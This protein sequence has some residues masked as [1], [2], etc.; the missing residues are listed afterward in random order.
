MLKTRRRRAAAVLAAL[1]TA[2]AVPAIDVGA[3]PPAHAQSKQVAE[4]ELGSYIVI[5][6][7]EPLVTTLGQDQLQS[8]G[9]AAR[10]AEMAAAHN[11]LLAQVGASRQ[12]KSHS[13]TNAVNGFSAFISHAQAEQ[14]AAMPGVALVVPDELQQPTT[15]ASGDYL[16][17]T[18][19]DAA[20][21]EGLTGEDVV[22][23]VIDSGIWPEH[24]SF[25][26]DGNYDSP[27]VR[28]K[29]VGNMQGQWDT[30]HSYQG[31][32]FGSPNKYKLAA[33]YSDPVFKCNN[34]L[35]GARL[36][37]DSYIAAVGL[38]PIEYFSARDDN[39]HG[40][41]TAST[42]AGNAGVE[43]ELFGVDRGT[44][45][46]IAPRA[47]IVAYKAL[48]I[49]GGT[50]SDLAMAIDLAVYDGVDVINYSIGSSS[51]AIGIDDVSFLFARA[52]GVHVATSNGNDG[53]GAA[54]IGSPAAVPWVTSVGASTH[55]RTFTG[56]AVLGDGATYE[57]ASVTNGTGELPLVDAADHGNELC[58][59]DEPFEPSVA[60]KIVLCLRG[61]NARVEKSLAVANA[62]GAGMILYNV[63][64][65]QA[66]VTDNHYVPSVHITN[67]NGLAIKAYIA[68]EGDTATASIVGGVA[69]AVPGSWMADF[70]SRGPNL[71]SADILKPDVTAPGVNILAGNT[72]T[73][74][75]GAPGE[76]FQSISGTS[77]S[78][79]HVAGL[80]ALFDQLHPDWAPA[81][82]KSALMTTARQDVLKEDGVTPADPFDM[83]AG[84]VD[85]SGS[86][87]ALGSY[88]NPGIVYGDGPNGAL[89]DGVAYL[90]H[91]G[92]ALVSNCPAVIN[93]LMTDVS[94]YNIASIAIGELA[95][96][97]TV[98]RRVTNVSGGHLSLTSS[99]AL[100]GHTV[101]V[102]PAVL[103]LPAGASATFTV[104]ITRT[105]AALGEYAFGDLTWHANGSPL[106]RSPI[107]VKPVAIAAP[108]EVSA[109]VADGGTSFEVAFGYDGEYTPMAHGLT[110]MVSE[111]G[112]V[113]QDPDQT[114]DPSDVGNGATAHE[115]VVGDE[116]ALRIHLPQVDPDD[117][118]DL[119]LF[120][121]DEDG[122]EVGSSGNGGTNETVDLVLPAGGTY[123]A[124]VHGWGVGAAPVDYEFQYWLVP[125]AG[126]NMT[127]TDPGDAVLGETATVELTWPADLPAGDYLGLVTHHSGTAI[128]AATLVNVSG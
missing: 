121:Y 38:T 12:Q 1:V 32:Q 119:D 122:N 51:F 29:T 57:G 19:A 109:A 77:M 50:S 31:C 120:V 2:A 43:A 18:A 33:G 82:A 79:P 60:G 55:D 36:V 75:L 83:G 115:L 23:G 42:A 96:Q 13:Y 39:G 74:D 62:G 53:P 48:G 4:S 112:N 116:V 30:G 41:H 126:G 21:D 8:R 65:L 49:Q 86:P 110:P 35:I 59:A 70:S 63:D 27:P 52:A 102:L 78:S 6:Q 10:A 71:Q 88:F 67:T 98:T 84:H 90:C 108:L 15:D 117:A 80:M 100:P 17:L 25:A 28:I 54:T 124:Y 37:L 66:L 123:T 101:T 46:G 7:G 76:L 47:R 72:P 34:K 125:A 26:D 44:V 93:A 89:W 104:E 91:I 40:T 58:L 45:S 114:F 99:A 56:A 16:G 127:A 20:Y 81:T 118:I 69:D 87:G 73:P 61:Q 14:L 111:T 97:Q 11:Q 9:A 85:P 103:E 95:G 113:G 92:I 105:D 107:A 5:L 3:A 22:V 24:P 68:S 106:A 64:D 94:N 128:E